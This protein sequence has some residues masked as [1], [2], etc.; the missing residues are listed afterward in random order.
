LRQLSA[1]NSLIR[2]LQLSFPHLIVR[3]IGLSAP[4]LSYCHGL[5]RRFGRAFARGG[6]RVFRTY[7]IN[8]RGDEAFV[9]TWSYLDMT[10]LGRQELWEDSPEGY[11]Q[12]KPYEWWNW[13]DE[14]GD[15]SSGSTRC[16][17]VSLLA[18]GRRGHDR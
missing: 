5:A 4:I 15:A 3:C 2:D 16:R 18:K 6:D 17:P 10:A 7:F 14:Y 9:G 13:H 12:T 8:N 1:N 11:P